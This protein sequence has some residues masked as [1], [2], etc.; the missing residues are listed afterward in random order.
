[1][2]DGVVYRAGVMLLDL[3]NPAKVI[4]RSPDFI[5]EPEMYYERAGLII[6]RVVFPSANAVKDGVV[7]VYYGCCVTCISVATVPL[8]ELLR[9]VLK[10]RI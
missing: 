2:D 7:Y 1:V 8:D 10:Y 9:Y 6:P 4:A 3:K 5:L